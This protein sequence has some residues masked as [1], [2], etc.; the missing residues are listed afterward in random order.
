MGTL[1]SHGA[2]EN[3]GALVERF[4]KR[5]LEAGVARCH[6]VLRRKYNEILQKVGSA[7]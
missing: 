5:N 1:D 4:V 7:C 2:A 3:V 6:G